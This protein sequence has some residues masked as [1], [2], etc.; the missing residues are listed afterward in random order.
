MSDSYKTFFQKL[1]RLQEQE[2]S[3]QARNESEAEVWQT[4]FRAAL[5]EKLGL[6][7][8]KAADEKLRAQQKNGAE[9]IGKKEGEFPQK[10][11][12]IICAEEV[13]EEGYLRRKYV[14]ETLPEVFMPFYMLIPE[15]VNEKNPSRAM[16]VIPAHGA[17]KN[18]VCKAGETEEEKE[19]IARDPAECYGW[20]FARRG[21]VVFCPDPP[22][23][24]ER[25]EP[26]PSEDQ[27]FLP[28]RRKSSLESSCKD[29][30]ETAEALGLS[31]AA[32]ELWDLMR[33]MDFACGCAEVKKENGI[34]QIGCGGFS[35]GGQ[36]AMW[37]AA[38][39]ERIGAAVVS[40][41]VHGYY[42][43]ILECH[44]CPCNYA[45]D[46]WR[47]GDISDICSL[48]APRPLFVENGTEDVENGPCGIEGP[49]K[50]VERIRKAYALFDAQEKLYHF[51]PRG[52]HRWYGGC[53][54]FV[55]RNLSEL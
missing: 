20:E 3:F 6:N 10:V 38:L 18:T 54:E 37:L 35:G 15:G 25:S 11:S 22:G 2:F 30:A 44:L 17:N 46:L 45:P 28:G 9:G 23:Y 14:M 41:Y 29:L 43:S 19:K 42:D 7:L 12:R 16:L 52:P 1:Y 4:R 47:L 24:G 39:D 50:Q 49:I 27:C 40:G 13:Q 26:V 8:L 55:E 51:T 33:L 36:Y 31:F 53:Y 48:I 32:L 21:Y 5:S 34:V